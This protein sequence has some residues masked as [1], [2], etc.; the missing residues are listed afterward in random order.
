M[1]E[2]RVIENNDKYNI[3]SNYTSLSDVG[4]ENKFGFI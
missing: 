1:T 3:Q 4:K 2:E